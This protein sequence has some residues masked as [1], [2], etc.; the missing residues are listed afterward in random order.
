MNKKK[1]PGLISILILTAITVVMWVAFDI[2]RAIKKTPQ[3][4]IPENIS[5]SFVPSLDTDV[6]K[7]VENKIFFDE[8][9]VPDEIVSS[10]PTPKSS[11]IPNPT[12]QPEK[13]TESSI[14]ATQQ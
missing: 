13:T 10:S 12:I 2:Y 5:K 6:I 14:S 7:N 9:Q 4:N 1:L 8:S 3:T 11:A